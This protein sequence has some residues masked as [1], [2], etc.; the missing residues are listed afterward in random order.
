MTD[1]WHEL[2]QFIDI[3]RRVVTAISLLTET[4]RTLDYWYFLILVAPN[5]LFYVSLGACLGV[6]FRDMIPAAVIGFSVSSACLALVSGTCSRL[7]LKCLTPK[8][9]MLI[10]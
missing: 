5:T 6:V 1:G 3:S 8:S 10:T 2:H 9:S 7:G 4:G